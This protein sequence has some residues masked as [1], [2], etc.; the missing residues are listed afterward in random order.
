MA[1]VR[2]LKAYGSNVAGEVCGV[3][4]ELAQVLVSRGIAIIATSAPV[5]A[6]TKTM[7][8]PV[9]RVESP[10]IVEEIEDKSFIKGKKRKG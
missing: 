3:S 2:M 5:E 10:V 6:V 8:A 1:V 7:A 4:D 9:E